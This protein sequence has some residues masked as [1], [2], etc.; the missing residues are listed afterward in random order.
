MRAV[1]IHGERDVRLDDV[2]PPAV[3]PGEVIL[4][5][6]YTG[7]C[8]S[9]LHLYFAPQAFPWD[10]SSPAQLT[11]AAW[12]QILGHEFSG[13][14]VE[15]GPGVE[16]LAVGD[17]VAVFP[18]HYCGQCPACLAGS[19]MLCPLIAFEGIQGRSGGMAERKIVDADKCFVLPEGLDLQLGALVEPMAVAWRGVTLARPEPDRAAVVVGGGPIGVGAYFALKARGVQTVIVSEPSAD[20]RAVLAGLGVE[21][22][23]DPMSDDLVAHS[24][25]L[26]DGAGAAVAI[27]CA[28]VPR[29]FS[30]AMR[31][32][33]ING[34][35]VI[36]ATYEKPIELL[37]HD[38]AGDKSI[39]SSSVYSRDDFA[40]VIEAMG[41][42]MYRADGG[43]IDTVEF[44]G[45]EAALHDLRAGKGMKVLVR[46][47]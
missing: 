5:G 8:G 35:M 11:G 3:G 25:K 46:T 23:V 16:N 9:D 44:E 6:G 2:D 43:W 26:T 34:R 42:G 29:A 18:Y 13:A 14:V 19:H 4:A 22:L 45:V 41:R 38:L 7:I 21:H 28:G 37:A 27:D 39:M 12:P 36:V 1:R 30:E 31:T 15:V 32:L 10:F 17:R 47:R 24:R 33:G 40:A 20:R